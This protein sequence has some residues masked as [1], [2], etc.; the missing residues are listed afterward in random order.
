MEPRKSKAQRNT[1][2]HLSTLESHNRIH[3]TKDPYYV[4][5][6]LGHKSL[7]NTEIYINL[8]QAIFSEG[9]DNE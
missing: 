6:L 2:S 8:E 1:L 5:K 3:R 9:E 7:R 4:K